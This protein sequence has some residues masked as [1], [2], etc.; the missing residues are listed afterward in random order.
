MTLRKLGEDSTTYWWNA[1]GQ[2]DSAVV[3]DAVTSYGY[4]ALG[5][6]IRVTADGAARDYI[7]D[8]ANLLAVTDAAGAVLEEYTYLPGVDQPLSVRLGGASGLTYFYHLDAAG[9]VEGLTN[10]AGQLA[11]AYEYAPFGA[12]ANTAGLPP[13]T[14]GNPLRFAGREYDVST[15]LYYMRARYYDPLL[16]R[17]ISQDPSG[18]L[19][20]GNLYA[21]AGNDPVNR[22]DP[23]GLDDRCPPDFLRSARWAAATA[24]PSLPP[25]VTA[26]PAPGEGGGNPPPWGNQPNP[27]HP[28][29]DG[30]GGGPGGD[31]KGT[32]ATPTTSAR[33]ERLGKAVVDCAL[34]QSGLDALIG[35]VGAAAVYAGLP[36]IAKPFASQGASAATSI[37]SQFFRSTVSTRLPF[38]VPAPTWV[39]PFAK[40]VKLGTVM[41]RWTPIVGWALLAYD[42]YQVGACVGKSY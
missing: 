13:D 40:S 19:S 26:C 17:F 39:R 34:E 4:D 20:G 18:D 24:D 30:S 1:A 29:G 6:R 11:A 42:A 14:L 12:D 23:F 35:G 22:R 21:Y 33:V 15:G 37:A 5:R 3:F 36:T 10:E 9:N 41:G 31:S 16:G 25:V 32:P 7:Y 8:G 2:L 38:A 28:V 27:D